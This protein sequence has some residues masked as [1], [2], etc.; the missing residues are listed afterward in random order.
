MWTRL[1]IAERASKEMQDGLY[2]NLGIGIPTLIATLDLKVDVKL[3]NENGQ[4][5]M[6]PYPYEDEVDPDII[7]PSKH[8]ITEVPGV[9]YF[10]TA[11]SFAMIRGGHIDI[12]FIGGMQVSEKGDLANWCIP[13]Q[14][15]KGMG[16]AMDLA[17]AAKRV[18][19]LMPHLA[20]GKPRLVKECTLPLTAVACVDKVITDM[21]V[22]RIDDGFVCEELAYG[23]TREM[24][25]DNTDAEVRWEY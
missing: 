25:K 11:D 21:G 20:R 17:T 16:G 2:V 18:I 10:N 19:I 5:G 7:S 14:L 9:S 15:I 23:V 3:Q 4:L 24:V 1:Q 22:F 8:T 12:S 6:G 13:G